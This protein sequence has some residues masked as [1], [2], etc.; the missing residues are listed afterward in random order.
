MEGSPRQHQQ[1]RDK[2]AWEGERTIPFLFFKSLG[3]N[4]EKKG[5]V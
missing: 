4:K 1:V 2:E 3:L 5:D